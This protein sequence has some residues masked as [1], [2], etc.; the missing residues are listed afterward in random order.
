MKDLYFVPEC[1]VDTN[2]VESLLE[3][4]GV[5]HQKGCNNVA[6][7]MKGRALNNGFAVGIIDTDKRQ[8]SYVKEFKEIAHTEHLSLMKHGSKP[9][10]L[11]MVCPAMDKFILDCAEK[12]AVDVS[13]YGLPTD[14][15]A[16]KV[17]TKAVDSKNDVRF[18]KLF[19]RLKD[20]SEITI[21]REVLN[22]LKTNQYK[23][24]QNDLMNLFQNY[25]EKM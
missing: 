5:N 3:V 13:N 24:S 15:D 12:Q 22:Y 7:T 1:Y 25:T 14:F 10:Y 23:S 21:L 19:K 4:N 6:N 16:F 18:K 2:L 9:H 17:Q 11:M 20:N 8:P